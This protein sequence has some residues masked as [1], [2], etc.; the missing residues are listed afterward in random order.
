MQ[1]TIAIVED[2]VAIRQNYA[3]AL[4]RYNYRVQGYGDRPSAIEAFRRRLP[5]LVIIDVGLGEDAE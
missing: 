3:E 5:D 4:R 1:R 2:E